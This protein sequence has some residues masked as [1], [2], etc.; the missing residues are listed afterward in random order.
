MSNPS[1]SWTF[2][3]ADESAGAA[4]DRVV[5]TFEPGVDLELDADG[6][7]VVDTDAHLTTGL[8]AVAQEIRIRVQMF[9]GEC[10][11]DLDFGI[12]YLPR[13][14]VPVSEA[15]LGERFNQVRAL[16]AFRA[17]IAAAPH[18]DTI[19][20]L[21]CTFDRPTRTMSVDWRVITAFGVVV[22]SLE[23]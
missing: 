6:D 20:S 10:F 17:A 5:S 19:D 23:I 22:D 8:D 7:L 3:P 11:T 16:T 13:D 2:T 18:A 14:G 4:L 9:R 1:A 12:P 15:L 21:S